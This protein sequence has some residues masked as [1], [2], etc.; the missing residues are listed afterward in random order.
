MDDA[1]LSWCKRLVEC[2]SVTNEGTRTIAELCARELLAPNGIEA[3]L[4]P[5]SQ[6]GAGQVNLFALIKGHDPAA[7]PIV[8][9]THLDTVPSGDPTAWTECANDPFAATLRDDRIYGLGAADTKLDFAAKVFAL[10]RGGTPRRD[11]Y[12]VG[13]FGEEHGLV[14]AKE[15]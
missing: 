9:N 3:R 11:T 13:T 12:L 4:L 10:V 14:G 2:R 5:S 7:T 15:M 8:L 1:L 6:E